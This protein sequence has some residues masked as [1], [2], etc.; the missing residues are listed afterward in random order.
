MTTWSAE[1]LQLTELDDED[2]YGP[3]ESSYA[4]TWSDDGVVA[5]WVAVFQVDGVYDSDYRARVH[6][7]SLGRLS[8]REFDW[9]QDG[10]E[11]DEL[12]WEYDC[13]W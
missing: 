4:W 7:D 13:P 8:F 12:D 9:Y 1:G 11:D 3:W 6:Y 10:D 5:S 2:G